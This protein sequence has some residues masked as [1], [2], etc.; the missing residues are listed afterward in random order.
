MAAAPLAITSVVQAGRE[1]WEEWYH[2]ISPLLLEL[3]TSS[4]EVSLGRTK[5]HPPA[6]GP[7][8]RRAGKGALRCP[9]LLRP[10][11]LG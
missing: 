3:W 10:A 2:H 4:T 7:A 11:L 9:N 1:K 5:S 6:L 8:T